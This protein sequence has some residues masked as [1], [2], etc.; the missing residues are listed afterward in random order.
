MACERQAPSG[1]A[2]DPWPQFRVHE[3]VS[4]D[5]LTVT[6][7]C[8]FAP[9]TAGTTFIA[10]TLPGQDH[11]PV[12]GRCRL[13]VEAISVY[14]RPASELD[15]NVSASL[16]LDGDIPPALAPDSLLISTTASQETGRWSWAGGLWIRAPR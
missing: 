2:F 5:P 15:Q 10:L 11:S 14:G 4:S 12:P 3:V 1:T 6:G 13:H 16:I 7:R 9:V 8:W